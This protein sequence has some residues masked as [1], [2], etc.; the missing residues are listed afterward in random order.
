MYSQVMKFKIAVVQFETIPKEP[1]KNLKKVENYI[2]KASRSGAEVIVFPEDFLT[3]PLAYQ[4]DL[5]DF[6]HYYR[7]QLVNLAKNNQI[8][9]VGGSLME[10]SKT[11][12]YNTSYYIDKKGKIK[13]KYNKINLWLAERSYLTHGNN[14]CVFNTKFGKMGIIICWDLMFPE[15]FRKMV[16]RGVKIIYCVSWWGKYDTKIALKHNKNAETKLV[17]VLCQSRA[18]E[19]GIILIY[20]NAAGKIRNKSYYNEL[21]GCSQIALPFIGTFKIL[22]HNKEEMF[23]EEV[24]TKILTDHET[25]YKIRS[26]IKNRTLN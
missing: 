15:I 25:G 13:G 19:N 17:N 18:M 2:K 1:T 4:S 3:G 12:V 24:D 26:D 10:S 20:C 23:I 7:D 5:I 6:N 8:D 11:G 9:V 21:I 14:I 22:D 16:S